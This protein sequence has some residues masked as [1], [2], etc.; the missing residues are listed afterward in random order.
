MCVIAPSQRQPDIACSA[1]GKAGT[2]AVCLCLGC[3]L[4]CTCQAVGSAQERWCEHTA[5][6]MAGVV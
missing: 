4:L 1:E 3:M 6:S 5:T 2:W